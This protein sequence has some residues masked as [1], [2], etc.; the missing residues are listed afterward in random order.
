MGT[1]LTVLG[2][3][4]A[5]FILKFVYDNFLTDNAE[6]DWQKLKQQDPEAARM[7]VQ[8][9]GLNLRTNYLIREDGLYLW[10]YQGNGPN[11]YISGISMGLMFEAGKVCKFEADFVVTLT[12]GEV[13]QVL[14]S[15]SGD[16]LKEVSP[17]VT[18]YTLDGKQISFRFYPDPQ[19]TNTYMELA[20]EIT[21]NG[22]RLTITQHFINYVIADFDSQI[23]FTGAKF[24]F[25]P[26]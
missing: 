20:G 26:A 7:I 5:L 22:L 6:K 10:T 2:I 23:L 9:Q 19:K 21:S 25:L 12:K 18:D 13:R 4:F 1:L 17:D 15:N 16:Y 11:G 8:N 24:V 3:A 14:E